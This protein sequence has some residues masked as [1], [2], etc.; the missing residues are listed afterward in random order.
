MER[1]KTLI[2]A[3]IIE[4][5]KITH[6]VSL[7]VCHAPTSS[8][9]STSSTLH[10]TERMSEKEECN[11][12]ASAPPVSTTKRHLKKCAKMTADIPQPHF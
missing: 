4:L 5:D 1:S 11:I 3:A 12:S 6:E 7:P 9:A 10:P 2:V 8:A